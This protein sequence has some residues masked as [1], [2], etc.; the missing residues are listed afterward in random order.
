MHLQNSSALQLDLESA[1]SQDYYISGIME[2][3][4]I[5]L[6]ASLAA[7]TDLTKVW[8]PAARLPGTNEIV[9]NILINLSHK[10]F[11]S[12]TLSFF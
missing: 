2:R 8:Q 4:I 5:H 12:Y 3:G 7:Q 1:S 10:S 9:R 11:K 6:F